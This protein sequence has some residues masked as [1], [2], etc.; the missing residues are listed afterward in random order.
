MKKAIVL[1]SG[2]LD[3]RLVVKLLQAQGIN[4]EALHFSN[5]FHAS[6]YKDK[7]TSEAV[8]A[9]K[10]YN[11]PIKVFDITDELMRL[12]E[13][14]RFGHGSGMNPCIDCRIFILKKAKEYMHKVG[15]GFIATGEVLGERPMSQ[16]KDA[17]NIIEKEAGL[18]GYLLRPLSARLLEPTIPEKKGWINR[19]KLLDIKGRSRKPQ[20]ELAKKLSVNNYPVPA[21]GCLLTDKEYSKRVKDLITHKGWAVENAILLKYGRHFRI[22]ENSKAVIGRDEKENAKL[23]KLKNEKDVMLRTISHPGPT[24]ILKGQA[25]KEKIELMAGITAYF[26]KKK[27]CEAI[28]VEVNENGCQKILEVFPAT[29]E[30]IIKYRIKI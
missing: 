19:E 5:I 2:G 10:E 13:C 17:L 28:K 4:I 20:I 3:S 26:V 8:S 23:E 14:P 6:I 29:E 27:K 30:E 9:A 16:R 12:V 11:I 24:S 21:G 15:A 7:K 18:K 22:D 1:L 25:S